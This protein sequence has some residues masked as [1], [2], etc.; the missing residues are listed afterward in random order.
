MVV[1]AAGHCYGDFTNIFLYVQFIHL[2]TLHSTSIFIFQMFIWWLE[3]FEF[4]FDSSISIKTQINSVTIFHNSGSQSLTRTLFH[5]V[6]VQ[7]G[8][9]AA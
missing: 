1:M 8:L 5:S 7:C 4:H 6:F 2:F 9:E 3:V